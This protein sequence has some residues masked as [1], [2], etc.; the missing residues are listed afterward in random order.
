MARLRVRWQLTHEGQKLYI[1]QDFSV[2]VKEKRRSFNKVCERLIGL[3]I[4]F[5]M[6]F[7]AVLTFTYPIPMSPIFL[8]NPSYCP[9]CPASAP[10][11]VELSVALLPSSGTHFLLISAIPTPLLTFMSK[12][13]THLFKI[14]YS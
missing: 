3:K 11:G 10:W 6:R 1:Q 4:R 2:A 12:L 7:P 8:F 9:S 13:K 14:A 5:F